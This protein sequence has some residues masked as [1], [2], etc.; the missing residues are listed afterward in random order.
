MIDQIYIN[1]AV[2]IRTEYLDNLIYLANEEENIKSLSSDLQQIAKDVEESDKKDETYYRDALFEVELM[3]R[4]A[5]E[6][7]VPYYE[8]HKELDK[9]Q[10]ELYNTIK[11][12]YPNLT[13]EDMKNIIIPHIVEV[14]KKYK[15]K[16]GY[17]I[18]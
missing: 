13:D 17:I 5:T 8:K 6:K 1:E 12:K 10:R 18:K 4:K 11:E 9:K 14:D 7:V 2:R 3:I 16:Y 15:K